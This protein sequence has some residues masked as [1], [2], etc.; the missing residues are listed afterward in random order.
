MSEY[1]NDVVFGKNKVEKIVSL[2]VKDDKLHWFYNDGTYETTKPKY[3]MLTPVPL[4]GSVSLEGNNHYKYATVFPSLDDYKTAKKKFYGKDVYISYNMLESQ[5]LTQ[6]MTLFKGLK[7]EEVSRLGFDIESDGL[8]HHKKSDIYIISNTFRDG[9]GGEIKRVFRQ[10]EYSNTGEMLVAWCDW[11]REI[12]P[13]LLIAHN[14]IGYDLPYMKHVAKLN[15]VKL[16]LGRDNSEAT[17][18]TRDR[19]L[20]VDGTQEWSYRD[21]TIFGRH[22][23]DTMFLAVKYDIGRNF[24]SWGLKPIIEHLGLV[25]EGRQFYDAA[26]IKDNW[27]DPEEREKIVQ[28]AIDDGDDCLNLY[29]I[30]APSYFYMC[31]SIPK[32]YQ[33]MLLGA[34]GSW[35]NG[36]MIR[37]YLQHYKS[38]PKADERSTVHGGISFGNIGVYDN[39]FKVDVASQYP[40]CIRTYKLYSKRKDPEKMYLTLADYFTEERFR[41]K[42]LYKET[43]VKY[44]DDMQASGKILI[45][46][47]FGLMGTSGLHFNDF[48]VANEITRRG[49]MII[50]KCCLWASGK[51]I[52]FYMDDYD[53]SKDE[54]KY[55]ER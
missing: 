51:D 23:I 27:H 26:K 8:V 30:M 47:L 21:C 49:R 28:Y 45:N 42:R 6:G 2:E 12:N 54:D 19:K 7:F 31:Q 29:E 22:V 5:M 37:G 4:K 55:Y 33:N 13:T 32:G 40:S 53:L 50:R 11:V 52:D 35:L 41:N 17:F 1:S 34:S 9:K 10:D 39:V 48:G 18:G 25:K 43:G 36:L 46:S 15:K 24:P 44:Y 20:R 14:G 16:I 3:W 38:I